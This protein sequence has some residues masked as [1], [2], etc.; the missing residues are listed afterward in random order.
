MPHVGGGGKGGDN[1]LKVIK[2]TI[3]TAI[4]QVRQFADSDKWVISQPSRQ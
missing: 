2:L 4:I 1:D 3:N